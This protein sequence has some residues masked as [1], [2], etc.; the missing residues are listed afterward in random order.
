MYYE[1]IYIIKIKIFFFILFLYIKL[2]DIILLG[3]SEMVEGMVEGQSVGLELYI[4]GC[5]FFGKDFQIKK[6]IVFIIFGN[7]LIFM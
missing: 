5:M 2:I 3:V 4:L 7:Y 6:V 1:G